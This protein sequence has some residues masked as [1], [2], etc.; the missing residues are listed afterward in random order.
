MRM[1]VERT[2]R[3]MLHRKWRENDQEEDPK[4]DGNTKL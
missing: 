3:K 1:T 2:P 4:P